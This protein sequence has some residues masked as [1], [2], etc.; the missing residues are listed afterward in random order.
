[1]VALAHFR[2]HKEVAREMGV[3]PSRIGQYLTSVKNKMKVPKPKDAIT[4]FIIA[5]SLCEMPVY[6]NHYLQDAAF[7]ID[8]TVAD[9]SVQKV[10]T[11]FQKPEFKQWLK[12][13]D[14]RGPWALSARFGPWWMILAGVVLAILIA[15]TVAIGFMAKNQMDLA[16]AVEPPA[17]YGDQSND[18]S[19][20]R[21][22]SGFQQRP[23]RAS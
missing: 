18:K 11:T 3:G 13:L 7:L 2:S 10:F 22:D 6:K 15:A 16:Y 8:R 9:H 23:A 21:N 4:I 5:R 20:N 19:F 1:M 17:T 14:S 12:D